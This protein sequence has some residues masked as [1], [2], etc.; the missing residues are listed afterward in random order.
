MKNLFLALSIFFLLLVSLLTGCS[1]PKKTYE[2]PLPQVSIQSKSKVKITTHGN[3][4][5]L[6]YLAKRSQDIFKKN[7]CSIVEENPDYWVIFYGNSEKRIDSYSD[8]QYNVIY[9]K[10]AKEYGNS[11]EDVIEETRFKTATSA[12]FVSVI[13]YDVKSM[14]P[15]VNF[16]FPFYSSTTSYTSKDPQPYSGFLSVNYCCNTLKKIL[17]FEN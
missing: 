1:T 5:M 10:V 12:H 6:N 14:T 11:G 9:K 8:N 7:Q 15:L 3:A 13:V 17:L 16:D 2:I 4:L